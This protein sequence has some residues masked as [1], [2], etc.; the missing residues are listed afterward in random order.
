MPSP[1]SN[2]DIKTSSVG[3]EAESYACRLLTRLGFEILDRNVR[4]AGS[5]IDIIAREN[6]TLCFVEVRSTSSLHFGGPLMTIT[7]SKRR[8]LIR[9]ARAYLL[10]VGSDVAARFDVI[11]VWQDN[12]GWHHELIRDAFWCEPSPREGFL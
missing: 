10:G 1:R 2:G 6:E 9:G 12:G 11:G 5:E 3:A 7:P 4:I 8:F